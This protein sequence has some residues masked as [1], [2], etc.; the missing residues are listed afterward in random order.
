MYTYHVKIVRSRNQESVKVLK[1]FNGK[2]TSVFVLRVKLIEEFGEKVPSNMS[3]P[4]GYYGQHNKKLVL[5]NVEDLE[6]MYAFHSTPL[7]RVVN[8]ICKGA[9]LA[10]WRY[11]SQR[12]YRFLQRHKCSPAPVTR[13]TLHSHWAPLGMITH[14]HVRGDKG[15]SR[16]GVVHV[17][18][19]GGRAAASQEIHGPQAVTLLNT[20]T[21]ITMVYV[22]HQGQFVSFVCEL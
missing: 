5:G 20:K 16:G 18:I 22:R 10:L 2:F 13:R 6:S 7:K 3:F 4:V 19:C 9:N 15:C 8:L 21:H 14:A 12:H 11:I 17:C 1:R